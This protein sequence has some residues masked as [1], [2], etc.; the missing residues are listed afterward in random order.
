MTYYQITIEH[1]IPHH[2]WIW[3]VELLL[4]QTTPS[5]L[6][7]L[8][9]RYTFIIIKRLSSEWIFHSNECQNYIVRRPLLLSFTLADN[10]TTHSSATCFHYPISVP[11]PYFEHPCLHCIKFEDLPQDRHGGGSPRARVSNIQRNKR[12]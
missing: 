10:S 9:D 11:D 6:W 2:Y 7:S 5:P 4:F 8:S 1:D 3:L 12:V